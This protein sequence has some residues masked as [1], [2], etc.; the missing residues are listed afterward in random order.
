MM[1]FSFS[2]TIRTRL[3]LYRSL[4]LL[5]GSLFI[6]SQGFAKQD[7]KKAAVSSV[8]EHVKAPQF[9]GTTSKYYLN[10]IMHANMVREIQLPGPSRLEPA[11]RNPPPTSA[12]YTVANAPNESYFELR[13]IIEYRGNANEQVDF[14][15]RKLLAFFNRHRMSTYFRYA[16]DQQTLFSLV[17]FNDRS[18]ASSEYFIEMGF[19]PRA[20]DFNGKTALLELAESENIVSEDVWAMLAKKLVFEPKYFMAVGSESSRGSDPLIHG[21]KFANYKNLNN[22]LRQSIKF[23]QNMFVKYLIVELGITG[24][25]DGNSSDFNPLLEASLLQDLLESK[26]SDLVNVYLKHHPDLERVFPGEVVSE[27]I[28]RAAKAMVA[29]IASRSCYILLTKG[30]SE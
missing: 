21:L 15:H 5:L 24:Y 7:D 4:G 18:G 23:K 8:K 26:D 1:T 3:W 25:L 2:Q 9:T 20:R 11:R 6:G 22:L 16:S 17:S 28:T 13:N 27:E 10:R 14:D 29:S 19:D 30:K 12:Y